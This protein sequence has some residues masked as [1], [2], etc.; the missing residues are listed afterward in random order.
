MMLWNS[1]GMQLERDNCVENC[2][3]NICL[4]PLSQDHFVLLS[5]VDMCSH[6][7]VGVDTPRLGGLQETWACT[8][9]KLWCPQLLLLGKVQCISFFVDT[10]TSR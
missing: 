5:A 4:L 3:E 9:S 10:C 7:R 2:L 6:R 1:G 8:I